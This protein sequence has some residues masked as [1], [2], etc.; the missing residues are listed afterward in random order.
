MADR[1][2]A[3]VV[4]GGAMRGVFTA[5][6]LDVLHEEGLRALDLAI[7]T[8]AG[9]CNL[10]SFVSG[11]HG[12]NLRCYTEIMSRPEFFSLGRLLRGGH[13]MELDWLWERFDAENPLD[14]QAVTRSSTTLISAST[15]AHSG[16]TLYHELRLPHINTPLK[17]SSALP[18]FYRGPVRFQD[19][20]LVDGGLTAPFPAE[21]AYRRG[22]RRILVV[23]TRPSGVTKGP[24]ALDVVTR[25]A[26]H[27]R[28]ALARAASRVAQHYAR[29]VQF[30]AAPPE[31]AQVLE[32]APLRLLSASRTTQD[33]S[34]L[35]AD[36]Q[37]GRQ[38]AQAAF[39][40]VTRLLHPAL[41]AEAV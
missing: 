18:I 29:A 38:V 1:Q 6:V 30:L 19:Q 11:Q 14:Q 20:A 2:S 35:V 31:D 23:R 16:R 36:Y 24:S 39:R 13:Y 17:G 9:A 40:E 7:G 3:I 33:A 10:A 8:S 25:I 26:L 15:C 28:P 5:G 21:E 12:R 41:Q 32:L 4:E 34:R 22:A 37:H 27:R